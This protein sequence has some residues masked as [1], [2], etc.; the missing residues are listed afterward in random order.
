MLYT[1]YYGIKIYAELARKQ[2]WWIYCI[3]LKSFFLS[4]LI[5]HIHFVNHIECLALSVSVEKRVLF[6]PFTVKNSI[7]EGLKCK[8]VFL[9]YLQQND[10]PNNTRKDTFFSSNTFIYSFPTNPECTKR[11]CFRYQ[12]PECQQIPQLYSMRALAKFNQSVV[13]KK[14]L[15]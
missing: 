1:K 14:G 12:S 5:Q 4:L 2:W 3:K 6:M 11:W 7:Q 15:S 9:K 8:N 13:K 10:N